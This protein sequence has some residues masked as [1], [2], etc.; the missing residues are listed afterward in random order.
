MTEPLAIP[1]TTDW[2]C[3]EI[4]YSLAM[5]NIT[6]LTG[7]HI[8]DADIVPIRLRKGTKEESGAWSAGCAWYF[9]VTEAGIILAQPHVDTGVLCLKKS[10]RFIE[11]FLE[12]PLRRGR[13]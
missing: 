7:E 4:G 5:F 11:A 8:S 6:D 13:K 1:H 3:Y 10:W 9:V 12:A 2:V